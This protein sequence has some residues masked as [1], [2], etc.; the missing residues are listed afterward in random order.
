MVVA[1]QESFRDDR[2]T[3]SS[4]LFALS[5]CALWG[6]TIPA[7]KISLQGLPPVAVAL[8]RFSI[9]LVCLLFFCVVTRT[10]W[11]LPGGF[12]KALIL[13][14]LIFV[15]Q[16]SFLY[17]GIQ[18]IS[19]SRSVVILHTFPLF[20]ALLAHFFI[21]ND[22]LN[23]WKVM[24][25][26]LA[27]L[28]IFL[29][30]VE[31]SVTGGSTKTLTGNL[32][33]L[34]GAFLLGTLMIY[35]KFLVRDLSAFQITVWQMIYGVPLFFLLSFSLERGAA[36]ELTAAVVAALVYQG[37]VVAGFCF[38]AWIYLMKRYAA[39]KLN[40]FQFSTPIFGVILSWMILGETVSPTLLAGVSLV[41][42]GIYLV[43]SGPG[44]KNS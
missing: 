15:A 7:V 5:L 28:G 36:Y 40:A 31:P 20:V 23:W 8:C 32:L 3:F 29:V 25:L 11:Q 1:S 4:V 24:G 10:T 43:S 35:I 17:L 18:L 44:R 33:V 30:F 22:R 34:V 42:G 37:V 19:A 39:S 13:F 12:H 9:A 38:V 2:I 14:S 21:P 16:F 41:A 6:G 26:V 27:F